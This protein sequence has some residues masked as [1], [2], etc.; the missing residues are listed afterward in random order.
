MRGLFVYFGACISAKMSQSSYIRRSCHWRWT[1]LGEP[2]YGQV[3]C[4]LTGLWQG[5]TWKFIWTPNE[6]S[7][8]LSL[9][10]WLERDSVDLV[11]MQTWI[12]WLMSHAWYVRLNEPDFGKCTTCRQLEADCCPVPQGLIIPLVLG[13]GFSG[14]E[15][16]FS[17]SVL[18]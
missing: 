12:G 6:P 4:S 14:K 10:G 2:S 8:H 7:T 18:E 1:V 3:A 9:E 13:M 17:L 5:Q 11:I 15:W 16:V